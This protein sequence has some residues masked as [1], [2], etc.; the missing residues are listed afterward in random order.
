M[1]RAFWVMLSP[2]A[3]IAHRVGLCS[4]KWVNVCHG[5]RRR[6]RFDALWQ[7]EWYGTPI[8][9]IP[10]EVGL[11]GIGY[12]TAVSEG[13]VTFVDDVSRTRITFD[14]DPHDPFAAMWYL[15]L[16]SFTGMPA[17]HVDVAYRWVRAVFGGSFER[18]A[19]PI[20]S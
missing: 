19:A 14:R 4:Y 3:W 11:C 12:R 1:R 9:S 18:R 2:F 20:K 13:T 5:A 7:Y 10:E 6:D 16:V 15:Q 17:S 8:G